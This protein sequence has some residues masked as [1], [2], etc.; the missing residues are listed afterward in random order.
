MKY[1]TLA[2]I[3]KK[4]ADYNI[5]FVEALHGLSAVKTLVWRVPLRI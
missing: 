5:V 4:G 3:L 2:P 1:Y